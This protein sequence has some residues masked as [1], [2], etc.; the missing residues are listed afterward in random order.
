LAR[1]TV[2]ERRLLSL[3]YVAELSSDEIGKAI[4][5]SAGAVRHRLARLLA[6][7]REDLG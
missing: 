4:G 5:A 1:L 7:L 3:R 2:D 6:R